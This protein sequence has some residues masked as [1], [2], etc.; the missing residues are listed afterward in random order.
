MRTGERSLDH[1]LIATGPGSE[2]LDQVPG[3]I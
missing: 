3:M 1:G 2:H